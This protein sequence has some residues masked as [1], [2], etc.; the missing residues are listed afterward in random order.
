[1]S[2]KL[3]DLHMTVLSQVHP[4]RAIR[5]QLTHLP[6]KSLYAGMKARLWADK[7]RRWPCAYA[8]R[9]GLGRD[10][11]WVDRKLRTQGL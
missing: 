1:M 9:R 2:I 3:P 7:S 10:L 11:V 4:Q 8:A 5:S 6:L